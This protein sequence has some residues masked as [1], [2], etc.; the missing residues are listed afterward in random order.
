MLI[1]SYKVGVVLQGNDSQLRAAA[2]QL[3]GQALEAQTRNLKHEMPQV[4]AI[5]E[6]A[7]TDVIGNEEKGEEWEDVYVLLSF[8]EKLS[9]LWTPALNAAKGNGGWTVVKLACR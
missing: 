6:R 1:E 5:V 4:L 9:Q 7:L 8:V 2:L 3:Y